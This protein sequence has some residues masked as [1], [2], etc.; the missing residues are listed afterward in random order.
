MVSKEPTH[1]TRVEMLRK[2]DNSALRSVLILAYDR[3]IEW[4]FEPGWKP[5]YKP[6]LL[7]I[8]I[9]GSL[10]QQMRFIDKFLVRGRY[11]NMDPERRKL[12]FVQLLEAVTPDD[13]KL[14]IAL[15]DKKLSW[16]NI[17]RRVVR[18]AI[19]GLLPEEVGDERPSADRADPG[20]PEGGVAGPA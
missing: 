15:K 6:A 20:A 5:E 11:P 7:E 19:P 3:S 16:P 13:A 18:E 17:G 1:R 2:H 9:E 4:D 14:L 8:D 12:L 10:Y